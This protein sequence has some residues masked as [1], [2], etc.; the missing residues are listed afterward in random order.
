MT[1]VCDAALLQSYEELAE[2]DPLTTEQAL[3]CQLP[4][5]LGGGGGGDLR[6]QE[7]LASAA[8]V[9]R[10]PSG[11]QRCWSARAWTRWRTW[12]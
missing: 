12:R 4:L 5:R 1:R 9:V 6:S 8:W 7:Q 3:Q 2:L 10:G 11:S